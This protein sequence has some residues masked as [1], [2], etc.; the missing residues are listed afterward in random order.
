MKIPYQKLSPETLTR[1][2]EE[3]VSREGTDYGEGE[4]SFQE[5]KNSIEAQIKE[6]KACIVFDEESESVNLMLEEELPQLIT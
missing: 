4:F 5:K 2:I 6:G 3:Y 1:V